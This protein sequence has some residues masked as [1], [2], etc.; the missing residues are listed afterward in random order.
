M[1]SKWISDSVAIFKHI[2]A[3]IAA[4]LPEIIITDS[5]HYQTSRRSLVAKTGTLI[6]D[7]PDDV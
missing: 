2:M 5:V 3:P 7:T 4:P 6:T 1:I